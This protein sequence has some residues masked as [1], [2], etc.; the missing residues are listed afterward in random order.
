MRR[1]GSEQEA[2]RR[3]GGIASLSADSAIFSSKA[4][5]GLLGSRC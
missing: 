5:D 3:E 2:W 4:R 1:K